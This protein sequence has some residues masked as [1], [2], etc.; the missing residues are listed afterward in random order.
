MDHMNSGNYAESGVLW[1]FSA[2]RCP[3]N[4]SSLLIHGFI[5]QHIEQ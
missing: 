5:S 4:K 1:T 2:T 3:E